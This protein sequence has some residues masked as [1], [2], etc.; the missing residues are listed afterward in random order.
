MQRPASPPASGHGP[1]RGADPSPTVSWQ[2]PRQR[3]R[4]VLAGVLL[5]LTGLSV[6]GAVVFSV[7]EETEGC[8]AGV[9]AASVA[10]GVSAAQ[11]AS[12]RVRTSTRTSAV[13]R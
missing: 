10:L 7:E 2:I 5:G 9:V 11:A 12:A 3:R 13:R 4:G 6:A 1:R 8:V